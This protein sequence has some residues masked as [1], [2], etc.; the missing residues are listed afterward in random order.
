MAQNIFLAIYL[1]TLWLVMKCYRSA[2]APPWIFGLLVLSKRLHSIYLLRFFNDCFSTL[3]MFLAIYMLQRKAY[4]FCALLYSLSVSVKMSSLLYLPAIALLILMST[5][6]AA[7]SLR[8]GALMAQLQLILAFP[9]IVSGKG[10]LPGYLSRA[11]EFSRDFL[12]KWTVNWRFVGENIF[13]SSAFKFSLLGL[14]LGLLMWFIQTRWL[15]ASGR[16]ILEFIRSPIFN[17]PSGQEKRS[18]SQK[19]DP[20]YMLI[21]LFTCNMIGMLCARS[22]HYQFY[23]WMEWTTPFLLWSSGLGPFFVFPVWLAQ[24]YAWNVYPSTEVSSA[25]AVTCMALQLGGVWLGTSSWHG[26]D[27]EDLDAQRKKEV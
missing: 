4:T 26:S 12:W 2:N 16:N 24:E 11:F 7:R 15:K 3:F 5:G 17:E 14:H 13:S 10:N 20:R 23:S 27:S 25:V 9:F 6:S 1:A 19:T 8:M 22:L 21:T 18:M